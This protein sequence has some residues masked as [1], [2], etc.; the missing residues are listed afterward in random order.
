MEYEDCECVT[1]LKHEEREKELVRIVNTKIRLQED[2]EKIL[3]CSHLEFA[4]IGLNSITYEIKRGLNKICYCAIRK[5]PYRVE[6]NLTN[7]FLAYLTSI[8]CNV[9]KTEVFTLK[10]KGH[11][12]TCEYS[13]LPTLQTLS[14]FANYS[15]G[16]TNKD[17]RILAEKGDLPLEI[18]HMRLNSHC[19][20][21]YVEHSDLIHMPLRPFLLPFM[22]A[23]EE[24]TAH[25]HTALE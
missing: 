13:Q 12:N 21:T 15:K 19:Y 4:Q 6:L 25:L 16:V 1:R 8:P 5:L 14:Y 18:F 9:P 11:K 24:S 3:I 17:L 23:C 20:L 10:G 22:A 7:Y 2:T